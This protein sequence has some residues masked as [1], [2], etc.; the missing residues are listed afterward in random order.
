M[1]DIAERYLW[2][3]NGGPLALGGGQQAMA[4]GNGRASAWEGTKMPNEAVQ[5]QQIGQAVVEQPARPQSW[6]LGRALSKAWGALA[7]SHRQ[8]DQRSDGLEALDM[9]G[10]WKGSDPARRTP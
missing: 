7:G 6:S 8:Q 9:L 5:M 3:L 1:V 4:L 10:G 2:V